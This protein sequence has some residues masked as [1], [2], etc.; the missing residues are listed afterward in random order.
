MER[1]AGGGGGGRRRWKEVW[2]FWLRQRHIGPLFPSSTG[3]KVAGV[4]RLCLTRKTRGWKQ[5]DHRSKT[6]LN[7]VQVGKE[8]REAFSLKAKAPTFLFLTSLQ[9]FL[10]KITS[11]KS[12]AWN[13]FG[14]AKECN[15]AVKVF[16]EWSSPQVSKRHTHVPWSYYCGSS[17]AA[18]I[19]FIICYN[20][21]HRLRFLQKMFML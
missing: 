12:W 19:I 4:G 6:R 14:I 5:K 11:P 17:Q 2:W 16:R 1:R 3:I 7:S 15:K 18:V 20:Y 10:Q 9:G 8:E 13:N 21:D